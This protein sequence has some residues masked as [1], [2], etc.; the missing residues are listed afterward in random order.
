MSVLEEY[1]SRFFEIASKYVPK[2][3]EADVRHTYVESLTDDELADIATGGSD[4][5]TGQASGTKKPA[6]VH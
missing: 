5:V 4:G 1:P 3:I 6:S 2:E